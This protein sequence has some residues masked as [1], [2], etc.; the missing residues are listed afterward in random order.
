MRLEVRFN[1][2]TRHLCPVYFPLFGSVGERSVYPLDV[3]I[4]T[5]KAALRYGCGKPARQQTFLHA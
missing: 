4:W 3:R 1:R 2:T 5:Y